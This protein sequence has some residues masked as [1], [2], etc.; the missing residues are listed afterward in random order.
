VLVRSVPSS[1][2]TIASVEGTIRLE[3]NSRIDSPR[4]VLLLIGSAGTEKVPPVSEP[5]PNVLG[6][7]LKALAP[8]AYLL[9]WQVLATDGHITRGEIPFNVR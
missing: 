9:R 6:G 8:G 2:S 1:H 5:E 3:F 4:S 7:R